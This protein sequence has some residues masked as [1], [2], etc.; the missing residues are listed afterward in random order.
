MARLRSK[1][2]R[3]KIVSQGIVGL[4]F[5]RQGFALAVAD[6]TAN[7]TTLLKHCEFVANSKTTSQA[8]QLIEC[9]QRLSLTRYDCALVLTA[10]HYRRVNVEQPPVAE[11]EIAQAIR[12]KIDELVDF[13]VDNAVLDYYPTPPLIR[14]NQGKMLDV[15]A[16]PYETIQDYVHQC[17]LA[18]LRLKVIDIQETVLANLAAKL[19]ANAYGVALLYLSETSGMIVIVRGSILYLARKLDIGYKQLSLQTTTGESS[20]AALLAYKTLALEIQRSL[21]YVESYYGIPP[22]TEVEVV[23]LQEG[24]Q[25]LLNNL[26][27]N[28]GIRF[29]IVNIANLV[30]QC[31]LNSEQQAVCALVAGVSLREQGIAQRINLYQSNFQQGQQKSLWQQYLAEIIAV[32][33]IIVGFH[34]YLLW[35]LQNTQTQVQQQREQVA[36]VT[37]QLNVLLASLPKQEIDNALVKEVEHW[38]QATQEL[39]QTVQLLTG[40]EAIATQGFSAYFQAL[41]NR[42]LP[43]IWLTALHFESSQARIQLEGSTFKAQSI[44]YFLQQLQAEPVFHGQ[45]F[46]T[47]IMQTSKQ[48]PQQ[49]DFTLSSTL[50]LLPRKDDNVR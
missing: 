16:S 30:E 6:Y 24:G 44:A 4:S 39:T 40:N 7:Q 23:P 29:S 46:A 1:F 35:H 34:A 25:Q 14:M 5:T 48:Q 9:V 36:Q 19:P 32:S 12:W 11:N 28:Y 27:T 21:D 8:E 47:L 17:Q 10:E 42:S 22:I 26:A 50:E 38:Q 43:D 13:R 41:A 31:A 33:L 45:T 49:L 37:A 15:V 18:G 3:K 20:A 2:F